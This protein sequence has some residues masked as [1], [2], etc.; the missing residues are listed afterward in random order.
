MYRPHKNPILRS[1][2]CAANA[3][4]GAGCRRCR[5]TICAACC[6][7]SSGDGGL[8]CPRPESR[9]PQQR[10]RAL[11]RGNDLHDHRHLAAGG[12]ERRGGG[13]VLPQ[14][15]AR[16]AGYEVVILPAL[17]DFPS[18]GL[19]RYPAHQR[20]AGAPHPPSA[21]PV[22]LGSSP[23]QDPATGQ[24]QPVPSLSPNS[25]DVLSRRSAGRPAIRRILVIKWS[26]MGDVIIATA[27]VRG[28][29]PRFSESGNSSQH[30]PCLEEPVRA[31]FSVPTVFAV[32]LRDRRRIDR[33]I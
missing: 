31:R 4:G 32:D 20:T 11:L 12:A 22:S 3:N 17:A 8:V 5:A 14:T 15:A 18:G 30:P 1:R 13:A 29:R 27:L 16:A 2:P 28:H 23:L 21:R 24:V 10:L 33:Q 7:L 26:A 6:A 9:P 25:A 19:R